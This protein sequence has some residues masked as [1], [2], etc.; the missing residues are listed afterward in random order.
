MKKNVLKFVQLKKFNHCSY[1]SIYEVISIGGDV[2]MQTKTAT[3]RNQV[4]LRSRDATIFV[5]KA[6]EFSSSIHIQYNQ[7]LVNGKSLLGVLSCSILGGSVITLY[8]DGSDEE[9]AIREL[10]DMLENGFSDY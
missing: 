9:D 8:A 1:A 3:V 6:N 10:S 4:G 2:L 7:K 5:S